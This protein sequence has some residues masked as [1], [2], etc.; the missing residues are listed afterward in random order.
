MLVDDADEWINT[1]S[2]L[3]VVSQSLVLQWGLSETYEGKNSS[4][5]NTSLLNGHMPLA[6]NP[7]LIRLGV[8]AC[9]SALP[10]SSATS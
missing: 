2:V 7:D 10:T 1:S 8:N 9:S 3:V 6:A 5:Q 4:S